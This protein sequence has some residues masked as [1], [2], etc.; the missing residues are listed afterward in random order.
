MMAASEPRTVPTG[1][2]P[3]AFIAA[4]ADP[5]QRA[6][7]AVIAA[8]MARLSGEPAR[9]WG[10]S[11][12]GYGHYR[13]RY[14]SGRE[15]EMCRIGFSPRKGQT[16][17]YLVDGADNHAAELARLGRHKTGKSCLYIRRLADIDLA[18]L[19]TLL[20]GSL[21]WMAQKYPPAAA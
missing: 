16:V 14:D 6:D 17:L 19:E 18:V 13:Y 4:V 1:I 2:D 12:I 7:A 20:A 9:M 10:P 11:I 21:A 5:A 8:L 3:E 15:G